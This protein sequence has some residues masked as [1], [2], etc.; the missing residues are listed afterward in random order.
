MRIAVM[1]RPPGPQPLRPALLCW[2]EAGRP[3]S[4]RRHDEMKPCFQCFQ[5]IQCVQGHAKKHPV[6][7]RPHDSK[8]ASPR[9]PRRLLRQELPHVV[10]SAWRSFRG[11]REPN[12]VLP[13]CDRADAAH[14]HP[15][16]FAFPLAE[17]P[18]RSPGLLIRYSALPWPPLNATA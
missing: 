12:P 7:R 14:N 4:L 13:R 8:H 10:S 15:A 18:R 17:C 9:V 2:T 5:C 1:T 16:T 6:T 3:R 11:S